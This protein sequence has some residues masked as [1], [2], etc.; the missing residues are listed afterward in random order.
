M[1][2][3]ALMVIRRPAGRSASTRWRSR[4]PTAPARSCSAAC[5]TSTSMSGH[6]TA[7]GSPSGSRRPATPT[8]CP[9]AASRRSRRRRVSGSAYALVVDITLQAIGDGEDLLGGRRVAALAQDPDIF[10]LQERAIFERLYPWQ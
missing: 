10:F 5:G 7:G 9:V 6:P 1:P 8:T 4:S 2:T 3:F